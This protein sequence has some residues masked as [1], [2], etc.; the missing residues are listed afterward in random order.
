VNS[1][2]SR[3]LLLFLVA[4]VPIVA[5]TVREPLGER[6]GRLDQAVED[7]NE[8]V[9]VGV[10]AQRELLT[11]TRRYVNAIAKLPQ[12]ANGDRASCAALLRTVRRIIEEGWSMSRVRPDGTVDCTSNPVEAIAVDSFVPQH[13]AQLSR[14]DTNLIGGYRLT[15]SDSEPQQPLVTAY[16]PLFDSTRTYVGALSIQRKMRWLA[17]LVEQTRKRPQSVVLLTDSAGYVLGRYPD[18]GHVTGTYLVDRSVP[19]RSRWRPDSGMRTSNSVDS[20]TRL[21]AFRQLPSS[22]SMPVF[23]SIGV[24]AH[25]ILAA[26]NAALF[27]SVAWMCLW[28]A[29]TIICAWWAAER[30][31]LRDIR[32]LLTATERIGQGDLSTRTGLVA[33]PGELGQ[34]AHAFDDMAQQL[35]TRQDRLAQ[36]QKMESVGQLAGGVAHDFNNLLTAIIGNTELAREQLPPTHPARQELRHVLDAAQRSARLTRQLLAFARRH[37]MDAHVLS[38]NALLADVTSLLQRVIGEHITL[39]VEGDADLQPTSIDPTQF[40]QLIMNLAVNARDAMPSGGTLTIGIRNARVSDGDPDALSGVPPGRWVALT[41]RDSGEGMTPEVARR[42][43]EPFYTTKGV[44]AGT[45]LGLAVVYGTVQQHAGHIRIE[46]APGR[47][48]TVRILL[49]PSSL[50]PEQMRPAAPTPVRPARGN[51]LLMLVEDETAVRAVTARLLRSNGYRVREATDGADALELVEANG[52][53]DVSLLIS[54]VVMPRMGGPEL[55]LKLRAER[56]SLPVLLVSGYSESGIPDALMNAPGTLFVEK[57]Y[58]TEALLSAVRR[59]L[60]Q[61]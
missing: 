46:T 22:A 43:F 53:S 25:P 38:L 4:F 33:H 11:D 59:L 28:I 14:G 52:F 5:L 54:D 16:L 55:A 8:N 26:A 13:L 45:G 30:V 47:G 36:A 48:T 44:G 19:A 57:P 12:I 41:V 15:R 34:L 18:E 2:R 58:S 1:I 51:E 23:L 39:T 49:P 21:Y 24:P 6:Q 17:D 40:E 20:V 3:L 35:E 60:D 27:R 61:R 7:V 32:A 56:G 42:A 9:E 29:V 50:E 31:V 10:A 37:A